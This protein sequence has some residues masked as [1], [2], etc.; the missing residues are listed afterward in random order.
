MINFSIVIPTYNS[1]N[2]IRKCLESVF[3]QS[4]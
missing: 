3:N 1:E 4:L 2:T